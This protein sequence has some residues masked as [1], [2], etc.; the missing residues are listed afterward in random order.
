MATPSSTEKT[1]IDPVCGMRVDPQQPRGGSW[2]H[3][4]QQYHFCNPRCREK[5]SADPGRYLAPPREQPEQPAARE[6]VCPM[7]PEIV[8][9]APGSCPICGMA[10]E[11][12]APSLDEGPSEELLDMQRRF[13]ISAAFTLPTLVLAMSEHLLGVALLAPQ[14]SAL[15]Q[16]GLSTP[17][18][19]WGGLPFF[20]RGFASVRTRNLNMFTLI[21][22]GT[23][24]AYGFSVLGTLLPAALPHALQHTVYFEAAAVITTL[25][26]LGQVLE[27]RARSATAGAIRALLARAPEQAHLVDE[28]GSERDVPLDQ[29]RTGDRLRVRADEYVPV[30]GVV[31]EGA[32]AVDESMLTGEPLPVAKAPGDTLT[33]GTLNASGSLIMRASRVGSETLLARIVQMVSEAQRSRAPI[34]RLAD[35]VAAWFV[36]CVLA[37]AALTAVVWALWGPE[38]RAAYAL[39][40]AVSVLIIACPCALGLATPM[41]IMVGTGRGAHAGVLIKNAEALE[42]LAAVDT[43]VVDKTG[44]L[45]EGKPRVVQL[46]AAAGFEENL[47]LALAAALERASEHPLAKALLLA[48]AERGLALPE[49]PRS[50][51]DRWSSEGSRPSG[52]SLPE[53]A[54]FQS[55]TGSGVTGRVGGREVAVGNARWFAALGVDL[56]PLAAAR[57]EAEREAQTVVLVAIDGRLAGLMGVADP[58]RESTVGALSALREAGL[59]VVIASGDSR[60][61]LQVIGERLGVADLHAEL[62]P[63]QKAELVAAQEAAGRVV[64]MAGDGAND[65]P[66]LA[67]ASVGIAMG[68]GTDVAIESAG[69]TLAGGDL[70]AIVRALHLSRAVMRN[71]RQNL[72]FAFV[73]NAL[74]V[75]IAAGAVFPF[76]GWLLSPMLASAAMA[77]SSVSVIANALRLRQVRL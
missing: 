4:G 17:V 51:G 58:L 72:F 11:P 40:N 74:G 23:G 65:A 47:V 62:S 56:S 24:A 6:Y 53:V 25:V 54:A 18:V 10:L 55:H 60:R 13:W 37:V 73:Y 31:L 9:N 5:F 46:V 36:P 68:T 14:A 44:T 66:A 59:R 21:A 29:V 22:L 15:A 57:D 20:Q 1:A 30:D 19:L 48:A 67:R 71:I 63:A 75:P 26:L 76:A 41:S 16:L 2:E 50:A 27:L 42:R 64:A 49:P 28:G 52:A 39:V 8:R 32:S 7:H 38:P 69:I 3:A 45:T 33:G 12:R 34:Q 61:T 70:R 35:R 43:L 77:V